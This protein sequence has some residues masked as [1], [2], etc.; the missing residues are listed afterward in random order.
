[1]RRTSARGSRPEKRKRRFR[2][3]PR[4]IS[5]LVLGLLAWAAYRLL[6]APIEPPGLREGTYELD[7]VVDGDTLQLRDGTRVRLIGVNTPETLKRDR[8]VEPCG[9]EATRFT[10]DFLASKRV[11]LQFDVERLDRY[12]RTLA[13]AFVDGKSLN[14]ALV[15]QGLARYEPGF[16]YQQAMHRRF[17]LA[18]QA[19][20]QERLGIWAEPPCGDHT[21]EPSPAP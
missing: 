7:F 3:G 5:L 6:T 2:R 17:R 13:Y 10:R 15:R 8:P 16:R 11:Q 14:E 20:R 19:A 21:A 1:M 4:W 9:P 12:G 18:E